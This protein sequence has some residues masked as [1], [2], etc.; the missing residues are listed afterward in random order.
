MIIYVLIGLLVYVIGGP[1]ICDP[2]WDI[3]ADH[4]RPPTEAELLLAILVWIIGITLWPVAVVWR[5][6]RAAKRLAVALIP[7]RCR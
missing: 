2:L 3:Q 5:I 7:A 6:A 1:G 4:T